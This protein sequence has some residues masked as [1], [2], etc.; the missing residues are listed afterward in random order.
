MNA[1]EPGKSGFTLLHPNTSI[2]LKSLWKYNFTPDVGPY[3]KAYPAGR[4][5]AMAGEAGTLMCSWPMGD[6]KRVSSGWGWNISH[7]ENLSN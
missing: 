4:W 5:Y 7:T 3:R 6:A 2:A 1:R